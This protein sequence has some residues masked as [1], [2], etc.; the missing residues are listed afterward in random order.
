MRAA[1]RLAVLALLVAMA[2]ACAPAPASPAAAPPGGAPAPAPSAAASAPGGALA[3][4]VEGARREGQL[5]LVWS[6]N[7]TGGAAA[8]R[9][10]ADGFNRY[11]GLALNVQFTPGPDMPQMAGRLA[12]QHQA[13]RTPDTDVFLGTET[14]VVLLMQADALAP[15]DWLAW[16]PNV[17]DPRLLAPGGVAVQV[18]ATMP[19]ITYNT[20]RVGPD[21]VPTTLEA[22]LQPRYKGRVASTPYAAIFDRLASPELWGEA[23]TV[24][25]VSGLAEQISGLMRAGE[26][27]RIAGGEFDLLAINTNSSDALAWQ[28]RGAPAAHVVPADAAVVQYRY[29]GVPRLAAHPN[30]ARLWINYLLSREAQDILFEVGY[31]DHYLLPGAKTAGAIEALQAQGVHFTPI[32]VQFVQRNDEEALSRVRDELQR[33]L[34]KR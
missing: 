30:A 27:E 10:W 4:L 16:A 19:G 14:H 26:V 15:V 31:S 7:T 3:E 13:G 2:A 8:V 12:Q 11:Y 34:Q 20:A 33:L 28:A 6:Q 18:T 22:L 32:D 24:A 25:Y 1:R 21:E 5:S 29:L 17:Q 9:R 23:R